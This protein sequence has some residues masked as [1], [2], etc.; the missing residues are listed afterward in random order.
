MKPFHKTGGFLQSFIP[1]YARN[2]SKAESV[3]IARLFFIIED[4]IR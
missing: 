3:Q 4:D 2:K 1:H